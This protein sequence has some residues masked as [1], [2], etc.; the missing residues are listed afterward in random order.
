MDSIGNPMVTGCC[1][2]IVSCN[3]APH[4]NKPPSLTPAYTHM[5]ASQAHH[6]AY[7][8]MDDDISYNDDKSRLDEY[9]IPESVG[10][11]LLSL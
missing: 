6:T 10:G 7:I 1:R 4:L 5:P 8:G 11:G 2:H 9:S 3:P